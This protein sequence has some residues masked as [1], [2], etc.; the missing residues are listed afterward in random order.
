MFAW[1]LNSAD[2]I[3]NLKS[4]SSHEVD[5]T[6]LLALNEQ[7]LLCHPQLDGTTVK[8][9][10]VDLVLNLYL[11]KSFLI[12]LDSS[13]NDSHLLSLIDN[14]IN[15]VFLQFAVKHHAYRNNIAVMR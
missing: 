4:L 6:L 3:Y 8:F 13:F 14:A 9:D 12:G 15:H 1:F 10:G 5:N 7:Q 2:I 11:I